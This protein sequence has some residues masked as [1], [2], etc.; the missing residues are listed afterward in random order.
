MH[1]HR[2]REPAPTWIDLRA[3]RQQC[4]VAHLKP[5]SGIDPGGDVEQTWLD[6][7][8]VAVQ[9]QFLRGASGADVTGGTVSALS[10]VNLNVI[11][12]LIYNNFLI[13]MHGN[14]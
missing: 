13:K 4:L 10:V 8:R 6:A 11:K 3:M 5:G 9:D 1:V 7:D 12:P 14:K 2:H